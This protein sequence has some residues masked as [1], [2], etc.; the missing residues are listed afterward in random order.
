MAD[1]KAGRMS[2]ALRQMAD[3]IDIWRQDDW[4]ERKEKDEALVGVLG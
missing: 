3:K 4:Y 2:N 1:R